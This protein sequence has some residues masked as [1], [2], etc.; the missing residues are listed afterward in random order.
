MVKELTGYLFLIIK[1]LFLHHNINPLN[2]KN[3]HT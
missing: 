3:N 1:K 2:G